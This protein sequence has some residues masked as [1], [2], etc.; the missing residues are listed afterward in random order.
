ADE[1]QL[2]LLGKVLNWK[3]RAKY[4]LQPDAFAVLS[5]DAN[6][7]KLIVGALLN[8]DQVRH[9]RD[10]ADTAEILANA[11]ASGERF[12]HQRPLSSRAARRVRHAVIIRSKRAA[13]RHPRSV[14]PCPWP[15]LRS[16]SGL[17]TGRPI[18]CS[19]RSERRNFLSPWD[20]GS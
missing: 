1:L 14:I 11:L 3:H 20:A 6:L 10:L 17:S 8:F 19:R 15:L 18:H 7:K 13:D 2:G 12:C 16:G 4:F 5:R 9:A